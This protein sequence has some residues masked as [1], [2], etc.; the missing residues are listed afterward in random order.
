MRVY[1][2]DRIAP[3]T[4]ARPNGQTLLKQPEEKLN[5]AGIIR[6]TVSQCSVLLRPPQLASELRNIEFPSLY[7]WQPT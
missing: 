5:R 2:F 4:L 3:R 7:S 6:R 1:P